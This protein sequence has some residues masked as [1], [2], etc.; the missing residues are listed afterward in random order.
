MESLVEGARR[1]GDDS[2][3]VGLIWLNEVNGRDVVNGFAIFVDE[4]VEGDAVFTKVLDVDQRGEDVLAKLVV[5]QNLV[6][7]FVCR[8][9]CVDRL[10]QVQHSS[11]AF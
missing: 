9:S 11:D 4:E 1:V 10:V 2:L 7:F 5:D 8:S 3:D 6:R